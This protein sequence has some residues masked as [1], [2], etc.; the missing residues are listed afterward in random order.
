MLG[1]L[2]STI[3]TNGELEPGFKQL[4]TNAVG[5]KHGSQLETN[6]EKC[7]KIVKVNALVLLY[8]AQ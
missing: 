1:G 4:I 2:G 7:L 5:V 6:A 3:L 8:S